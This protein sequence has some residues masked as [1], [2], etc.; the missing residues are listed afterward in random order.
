MAKPLRSWRFEGDFGSVT[1]EESVVPDR[2]AVVLEN[3]GNL[4]SRQWLDEDSFRELGNLRYTITFK[5][6]KGEKE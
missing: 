6:E 2:V 3:G 4:V 1:I 5:K